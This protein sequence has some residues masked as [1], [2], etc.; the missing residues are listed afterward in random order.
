MDKTLADYVKESRRTGF[1]L[2]LQDHSAQGRAQREIISGEI[3]KGFTDR[4]ESDSD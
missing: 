2:P 1:G 4:T 3:D